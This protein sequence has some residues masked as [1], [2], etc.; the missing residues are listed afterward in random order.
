MTPLARAIRAGCEAVCIPCEYPVCECS[1]PAVVKAA[2]AAIAEP[3]DHNALAGHA[4]FLA[5]N[6]ERLFWLWLAFD[7][8]SREGDAAGRPWFQMELGLRA[9][10]DRFRAEA[11]AAGVDVIAVSEG[12]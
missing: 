5:A 7:D 6:A 3:G 8:L 11:R 10:C 2:L 1:T 4:P 9:E 12:G